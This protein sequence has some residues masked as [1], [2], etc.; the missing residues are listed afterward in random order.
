MRGPH[1][2]CLTAL[3]KAAGLT[4]LGQSVS[5]LYPVGSAKWAARPRV[6]R[7][8]ELVASNAGG[9]APACKHALALLGDS[10]R[11]L[12]IYIYGYGRGSSNS[13][14]QTGHSSPVPGIWAGVVVG[15]HPRGL[16]GCPTVVFRSIAL[17]LGHAPPMCS[18]PV[19]A[20]PTQRLGLAGCTP[21]IARA[22]CF[23]APGVVG[24][25]FGGPSV[26]SCVGRVS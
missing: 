22:L 21:S 13:S 23:R 3:I 15:P 19:A 16:V 7:A 18:P 6:S 25:P 2:P 8:V 11:A 24:R 17:W 5:G 12:S 14:K 20:S 9:V 26:L 1:R 10:G 4:G